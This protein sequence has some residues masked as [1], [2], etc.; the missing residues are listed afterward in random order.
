MDH[1]AEY[2][3]ANHVGHKQ[4]RYLDDS[5]SDYLKDIHDI[6]YSKVHIPGFTVLESGEI[7][8]LVGLTKSIDPFN[9]LG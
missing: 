4:S 1:V 2:G 5:N 8:D 7:H 3:Q 9:F 6:D